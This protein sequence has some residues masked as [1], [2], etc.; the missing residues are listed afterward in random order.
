[1]TAIATIVTL[2]ITA[3]QMPNKPHSI[4]KGARWQA[5]LLG[6]PSS[7][8]VTHPITAK[9]LPEVFYSWHFFVFW[10]SLILKI[11]ERFWL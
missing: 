3:A 9:T 1:M 10:A 6:E 7:S 4:S 2:E 8:A 5:G 11:T